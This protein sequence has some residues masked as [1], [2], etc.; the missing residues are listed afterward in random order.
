LLSGMRDAWIT[1]TQLRLSTDENFDVYNLESIGSE[2]RR[3][4]ATLEDAFVALSKQAL[5]ERV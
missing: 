2:V 4:P 5:G 3:V 1:G